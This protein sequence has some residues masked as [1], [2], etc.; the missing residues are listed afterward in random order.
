[1]RSWKYACHPTRSS[2]SAQETCHTAAPGSETVGK[3]WA[4]A[5]RPY[6]A[7]SHLMKTGSESPTSRMT[8][9]GMRHIHQPL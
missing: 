3:P 5:R 7:S 8:A 9:V 2:L 4:R 1:M 6:S